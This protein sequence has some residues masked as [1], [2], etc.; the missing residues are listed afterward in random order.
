MELADLIAPKTTLILTQE[1]QRG[2]VGDLGQGV[3]P[4]AARE[5]GLMDHAARIVAAG[6]A[7]G[8]FV[9]HCVAEANPYH[10]ALAANAPILR[11]GRRHGRK[12]PPWDARGMEVLD[13]VNPDGTDLVAVRTV[14]MSPIIGTEVP[15]IIRNLG[16]RTVVAIG[17]SAN[18]GIPNVAIDLVNLGYDVVIPRDAI[19]GYPLE[20]TQMMVKHTLAMLA[21]ICTTDELIALWSAS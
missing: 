9:L 6:R 8:C 3:L 16:I 10:P 12:P 2:I 1:L 18:L 20:Y 7:A 21:K 14:Q 11:A 5:I 13:A 4:D 19:V 17:V 15:T